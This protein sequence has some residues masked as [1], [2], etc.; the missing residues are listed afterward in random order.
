MLPYLRISRLLT[1]SRSLRPLGSVP[2]T[3]GGTAASPTSA[4]ADS[5]GNKY[6]EQKPLQSFPVLA[7]AEG[8][9]AVVRLKAV[10][11]L[12]PP[13]AE[14]VLLPLAAVVHVLPVA[15]QDS[16]TSGDHFVTVTEA[17]A[18]LP[19]VRGVAGHIVAAVVVNPAADAVVAGP[20]A[21]AAAGNSLTH[22]RNLRLAGDV[23][24][25]DY[26]A[27]TVAVSPAT[28]EAEYSGTLTIN[29]PMA[30]MVRP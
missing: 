20:D 6:T 30:Y 8:V 26:S 24:L 23:S 1:S 29:A 25:T 2:A 7:T 3:V 13:K 15:L 19:P 17:A 9:A 10:T 27:A 28:P 5:S 14:P 18:W 22:S 11:L 12:P 4:A 21:G 16:S